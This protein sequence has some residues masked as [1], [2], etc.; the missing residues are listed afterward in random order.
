MLSSAVIIWLDENIVF[1]I[2][3]ANNMDVKFVVIRWLNDNI[4]VNIRCFHLAG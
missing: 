3:L 2:S 4:E 1:I